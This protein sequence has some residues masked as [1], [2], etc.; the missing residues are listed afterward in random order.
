M[1]KAWEKLQWYIANKFK[2]LGDDKAKP[3]KGSGNTGLGSP[4]DVTTTLP[5]MVECKWRNTKNLTIDIDVFDKNKNNIPINSPKLPMLALENENGRKFIVMDADDFFN[6]L[7][8][9]EDLP[10]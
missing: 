5:F 9:I 7:N 1:L 3:T 8:E 10:W 6:M 4:S 2:E